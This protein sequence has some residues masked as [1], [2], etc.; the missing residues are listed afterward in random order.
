MPGRLS[1]AA[2][3]RRPREIISD[4]IETTYKPAWEDFL[5][6]SAVA[7]TVEEIAPLDN[8]R[9]AVIQTKT[10]ETAYLTLNADE[11]PPEK[12]GSVFVIEMPMKTGKDAEIVNDVIWWQEG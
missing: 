8:G 1:R 3:G 11:H 7:G 12:G 10:G 4:R 5:A 9:R 2:R 6:N